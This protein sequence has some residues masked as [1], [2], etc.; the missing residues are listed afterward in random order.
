LFE[1]EIILGKVKKIRE[2][3]SFDPQRYG[4]VLC[5]LCKGK[6]FIINPKRKCCQRCGGFGFIKTET[7]E[8]E[9][10]QQ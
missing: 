2:H 9:D 8:K 1:G 3:K 6:G 5:P 7:E 10:F 4:M